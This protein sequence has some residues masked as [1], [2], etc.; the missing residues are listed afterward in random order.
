MWHVRMNFMDLCLAAAL[1]LMQLV[2]ISKLECIRGSIIDGP[3]PKQA[4]LNLKYQICFACFFSNQFHSNHIGK[5]YGHNMKVN[6]LITPKLV[7]QRLYPLECL[8]SY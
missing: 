6:V 1:L 7:K 2:D 8:C 5:R 4:L 3:V